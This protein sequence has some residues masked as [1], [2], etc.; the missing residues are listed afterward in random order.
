M[1]APF[2]NVAESIARKTTRRGFFDRGA[3]LLFGA[4]A[5]TAAGTMTRAGG[6]SAGGATVCSF[7]YAQPCSCADCQANG[8]CAKPCVILTQ[9]YATGCWVNGPVTCCD[10][11]CQDINLV[12]WCGCGTD[13]H[14]DPANCPP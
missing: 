12:S 6:V 4:L 3:E 2:R 7:P 1:T 8:V 10:C 9:F 14:N 13:Y 5:G 11:D